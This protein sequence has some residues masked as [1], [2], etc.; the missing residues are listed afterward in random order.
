VFLTEKKDSAN[1]RRIFFVY[2]DLIFNTAKMQIL[3]PLSSF[4]YS[5]V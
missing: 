2:H 3:V 4:K 5:L 1:L